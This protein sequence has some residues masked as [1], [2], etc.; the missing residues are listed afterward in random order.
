MILTVEPQDCAGRGLEKSQTL[1]ITSS[2]RAG[3]P[4]DER[5]FVKIR[6]RAI[7]DGCKWDPQV[8]D[9]STLAPFPLLLSRNH[10]NNL[11]CFTE[12]LTIET[13][14]AEQEILRRPE[15]LRILGL[16][17]TVCNALKRPGEITPAAARVMRFDFHPTRD[18][19]R[20]S[21]VNSD[22]PGGFTEASFF[23]CLI[24]E[25]FPEARPSGNPI[26][27]WAE[28]IADSAGIA[29][30]VALLT[31]PGFME[32]HQIIAYL[33][34]HLRARGCETHLTNPAQ[35]TWR[36][37][38]AYL[39]TE[40][41]RGKLDAVVRF[42]QAEWMPYLPRRVRWENFLRG[43]RTPVGN[44]GVAV[45][46]ESKRFPLVWDDLA[47]PLLTWRSLLPETCDTREAPW[48]TD[49]GWLVKAAMSNTGDEVCVRELMK[50]REWRR[51]SWNVRLRPRSWVAQRRFES[52]PLDTPL[53]PM[54]VCLGVYS[55]NGR[56]AGAYARFASRPV[57]D[58]S[59]VDT[60]VLVLNDDD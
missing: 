29:G 27:R 54:H 13:L 55:I 46:A 42:F 15:L 9:V 56:T 59:A 57:I 33:A 11:A 5:A 41:F 8:G 34:E 18:G 40:W 50:E 53:G 30:K 32:D 10:W 35:L 3:A 12:Q 28:A 38:K 22:V 44:P 6:R 7:L 52:V 51:V 58:Y 23:T 37:H 26:D 2:M 4:L 17:R 43:G 14:A 31:A 24:A 47:T 36:E 49:D 19:W 48:Q 39:D 20:I 16:P 60:A 45:L 21:E 1:P 25:Y